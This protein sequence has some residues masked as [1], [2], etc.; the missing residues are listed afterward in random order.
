MYQLLCTMT[1]DLAN[2]YLSKV[3]L[4]NP[5]AFVIIFWA[6]GSEHAVCRDLHPSRHRSKKIA[7]LLPSRHRA[8]QRYLF[9]PPGTDLR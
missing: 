3:N 8:R 7:F 4:G 6:L 9:F 1:H 2:D 5:Q